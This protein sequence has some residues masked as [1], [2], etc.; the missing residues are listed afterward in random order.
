MKRNFL[1]LLVIWSLVAPLAVAPA[2]AAS[3][4]PSAQ[5]PAQRPS[6]GAQG[7]APARAAQQSQFVNRALANGLEVV[8]LEDHSTPLVTVELAVRNG[9]YTEPPEL[10]GLSHLYEHMFFKSNRAIANAEEYLRQI[11]QMGI[12]YNGQTQTELVNYYYTTTSP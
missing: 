5:A 6:S 11:G 4:L 8:V 2:R 7:A 1:V 10:N 3:S 9:S 12:A